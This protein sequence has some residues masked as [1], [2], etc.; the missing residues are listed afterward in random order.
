[1]PR[2]IRKF[3]GA[4]VMLGFVCLY[5]LVA[6][7]VAQTDQIRYANPVLQAVFFLVVGLAWILPLMPLIRWMERP[8]AGD[9]SAG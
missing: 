9:P 6:M 1:M 3:I 8:D 2:R 7:L 4:F 5:G